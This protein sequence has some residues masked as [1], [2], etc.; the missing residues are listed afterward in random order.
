MDVTEF[1]AFCMERNRWN[2]LQSIEGLS[3]G[4]LT[5]QPHPSANPIGFLLFHIFRTEDRYVHRV[6]GE[7]DEVW[8][9]DGWDR[10]WVLPPHGAEVTPV[11]PTGQT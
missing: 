2:T 5:W 8:E 11:W 9:Q 7:R 3:Q 1:V 6:L 10:R 4:D